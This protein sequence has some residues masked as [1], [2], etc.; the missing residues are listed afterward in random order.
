MDVTIVISVLALALS[1]YSIYKIRKIY[2][3]VKFLLQREDQL[4]KEVG[5]LG[6][7]ISILTNKVKKLEKNES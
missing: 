2:R 3:D 7:E 4:T 6:I 1:I 5:R